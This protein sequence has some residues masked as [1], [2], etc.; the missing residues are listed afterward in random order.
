MQN[1]VEYDAMSSG[2]YNK[3]PLIWINWDVEPSG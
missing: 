3:I 2:K 1:F